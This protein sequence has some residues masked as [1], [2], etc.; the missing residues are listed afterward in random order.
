MP[1]R[2]AEPHENYPSPSTDSLDCSSEYDHDHDHASHPK[3]CSPDS[4]FEADQSSD[5]TREKG[6]RSVPSNKGNR[7]E[8]DSQAGRALE[9][10]LA[11]ARGQPLRLGKG[12]AAGWLEISITPSRYAQLRR[13][14]QQHHPQAWGYFL[15]KIRHDYDPR[16]CLLV[17]RL[18]PTLVHDCF[19]LRVSDRINE[20]IRQLR[21]DQRLH[22]LVRKAISNID[23]AGTADV[24]IQVDIPAGPDKATST[25]SPDGQY[26]YLGHKHPPFV[27][28]IAYSQKPKDL[29]RLAKQ[30]Y[31]DSDGRIKT[32][33]TVDLEYTPKARRK[34][35][36]RDQRIQGEQRQTRSSA[37]GQLPP[38]TTQA[39]SFSL[40]RG[41]DRIVSNQMFR[42]QAGAPIQGEG[43]TLQISDL[44]PDAALAQLS[45]D[46][47][48]RRVED[49]GGLDYPDLSLRFTSQELLDLLV[50]SEARQAA[51]DRTR[52]L[53][54]SLHAQPSGQ[55]QR[56][57]RKVNWADDMD[58]DEEAEEASQEDKHEQT[59]RRLGSASFKR[60]RLS[61][62]SRAYSVAS[63][64]TAMLPDHRVTRSLSHVD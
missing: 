55:I 63:S 13:D 1:R 32:V 39:A 38:P 35:R 42:D 64:G 48:K 2:E 44:I 50:R 31:E 29:P 33:L 25:K 11:R 61:P 56:Q 19:L 22:E 6:P 45:E 9:L 43:F 15:D 36:L 30:Y 60:R 4:S 49:N 37:Q 46:L 57:K 51:C 40:Y 34:A 58:D 28:E 26:D 7:D 47:R 27:I 62:D 3:K 5:K 14:L 24:E 54:P 21:E 59:R 16:D 18:M 53:S 41:P 52:S 17:L 8:D 20:W 23:A 12:E 10:I